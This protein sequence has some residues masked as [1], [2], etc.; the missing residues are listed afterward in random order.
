MKYSVEMA[1]GAL[2]Y[3]PNFIRIVL[4]IQKL[5][6]ADTQAHRAW[7]SHKPTFLFFKIKEVD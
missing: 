2:I 4:S 7:R 6:R 5:I 3:I 1:S